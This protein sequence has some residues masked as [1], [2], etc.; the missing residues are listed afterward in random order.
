MMM[1]LMMFDIDVDDDDN[2]DDELG[3]V[4]GLNALTGLLESS[5]IMHPSSGS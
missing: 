3:E 5:M 2:D 4:L 1:M